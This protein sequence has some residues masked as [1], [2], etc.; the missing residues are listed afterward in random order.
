MDSGQSDETLA[1][2]WQNQ[3][4]P[5]KT[6]GIWQMDLASRSGV[7]VQVLAPD[8]SW[9]APWVPDAFLTTAKRSAHTRPAELMR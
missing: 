7:S 1:K 3:V 6:C 2:V 5:G 4:K 9:N 8:H